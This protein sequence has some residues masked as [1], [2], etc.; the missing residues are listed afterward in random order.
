MAVNSRFF[1]GILL[2]A[3]CWLPLAAPVSATDLETPGAI[4]RGLDKISGRATDFELDVGESYRLGDLEVTL[5]ACYMRPPIEPPESKA[6]LD[7]IDLHKRKQVVASMDTGARLDSREIDEQSLAFKGWMFASVPGLNAME[8]PVY[9]VWVI[10]CK[11]IPPEQLEALYAE[12]SSSVVTEAEEKDAI[13]P[14]DGAAVSTASDSVSE[15]LPGDEIEASLD[16]LLNDLSEG[17]E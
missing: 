13:S 9:D 4:L 14:S 6:Y 16:S 11:A 7:V 17:E 10:K 15:T 1:T 8:H 12:L 2:S 3:F 5:R